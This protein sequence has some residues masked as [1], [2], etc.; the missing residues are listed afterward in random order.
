MVAR[1]PHAAGAPFPRPSPP[2]CAASV[3]GAGDGADARVGGGEVG[4]GEFARLE[5]ARAHLEFALALEPE[6]VQ[7]HLAVGNL[8]GGVVCSLY[9]PTAAMLAYRCVCVCVCVRARVCV[10]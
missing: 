1:Q 10:R 7:G 6:N 4:V 9:D 2:A 8:L 5:E 3:R